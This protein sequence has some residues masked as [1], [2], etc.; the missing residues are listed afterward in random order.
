MK[1]CSHTFRSQISRSF[2]LFAACISVLAVLIAGAAIRPEAAAAAS[3]RKVLVAPI[4]G[5]IDPVTRDFV[6]SILR[7]GE[8]EDVAAVVFEMDTPGGLMSSMDE[9]KKAFLA[10]KQFPV[11]VYVAPS[12]ARAASAGAF[13]TMAS[14]VAAMAPGTNIGSATPIQ[15]SGKNIG[16]D[17]RKKVINDAVASMEALARE[18]KRDVK[19]ARDAIVDAAN[20]DARVAKQRGVVEFI[21][22]S[23]GDLLDQADGY[24][25]KPKGLKV[26][27]ASASITRVD[28]PWTQ[29]ILKHI[30]DPNIIFLLFSAGIIGLGFELTH[31][32]VFFPGVAGAIC[33]IIALYGLQV[34]PTSVAGVV[35]LLLAA[36]FFAAEIAVVSHGVLGAGGAICLFLGGLLLFKRDSGLAVDIWL[37]ISITLCFAGFFGFVVRKIVAARRAPVR[38]GVEGLVG[39]SGT[40]RR[41][42]TPEG[43]VYIQGE[44]WDAVSEDGVHI[45][46]DQRVDVVRVDGMHLHVRSAAGQM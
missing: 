28:M 6:D 16:G 35:L 38:S 10:E 29:R 46:E 14:D 18:H 17:L 22:P 3:A 7:R 9:I 41:A 5:A 31:P 32:G 30:I 2:V 45:A 42:L 44:L 21:S 20:I 39:S 8:R 43:R 40:V 25:T 4:S 23:L 26:R 15:G 1:T 12:G 19:F 36:A 34:L 33:M 24:V 37:L 13:I 27:T 11:F